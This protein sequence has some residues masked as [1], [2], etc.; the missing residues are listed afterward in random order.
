MNVN[1]TGS[2]YIHFGSFKLKRPL[3]S[4][5]FKQQE[6]LGLHYFHTMA[7]L[8]CNVKKQQQKN[9]NKAH[10]LTNILQELH[11]PAQVLIKTKKP[12]H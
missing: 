8:C 9:P 2:S 7:E 12:L 6:M 4:F 1:G 11:K 3:K 5:H 10:V